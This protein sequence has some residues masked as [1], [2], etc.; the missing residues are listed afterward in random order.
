MPLPERMQHWVLMASFTI[1]AWSGFALKYPDQWWAL[2]LSWW[3]TSWPVRGI[4]HRIAATIFV[5]L[6]SAHVIG[7]I[8]D[9]RMRRRWKTLLP[10]H[11][12]IP[13]AVGAFAYNTGLRRTSPMNASHAWIAKT[14]YWALVWG[15]ALMSITGCMLWANTFVLHW[16]PRTW[17]DVATAMHFYEAVLATLAILVWHMYYVMFD[18]DVYPMDPSWL[19]GYS[20]RGHAVTDGSPATPATDPAA[21]SSIPPK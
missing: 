7:I 21:A 4:V 1:L 9:R 17:L 18:P 5:I 15:A 10:K 16:L 19:T 2:P 12:D 11:R 20:A 8:T 13:A 3:E 6:G 14:E